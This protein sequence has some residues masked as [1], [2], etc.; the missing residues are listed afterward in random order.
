MPSKVLRK[1]DGTP[2]PFT[3]PGQEIQ[4]QSQQAN[5]YGPF[6]VGNAQHC[7]RVVE[8]DSHKGQHVILCG[9]GPSLAEHAAEWI[10]KGDVVM[11]TNSAATWL[12]DNGYRCDFALAIDQNPEMVAEWAS[13]PDVEYLLASTVHPHLTEYLLSKGRTIRWF[14]N[15]VGI[16]QRPVAYAYCHTCEGTEAFDAPSCTKC[17]AT[18]LERQRTSYED[19]LYCSLYPGTVRAGSGLNAVTR[20]IDVA[21]FMGFG[22]ITVLG[23]DHALRVKRPCP[24][25]VMFG[26]PEY[27]AWVRDETI[28]HADGG[29]GLASNATPVTVQAEIDSGT[30][31]RTVRPGHG[32]WWVTKPDMMLSAVWLMQMA[33][34]HPEIELIGET[35]SNALKGKDESFINALPG[36]DDGSG[37]NAA[38]SPAMEA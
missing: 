37:K 27:L 1:K 36:F 30:P 7:D 32:R 8:Q 23:A 3:K 9:A 22:R 26:T 15:F 21:R 11:A 13:A 31:D 4:L 16:K 18:E 24:A 2:A 17:G 14:H 25:D 35:L 12:I 33:K 10:P 34:H 29:S 5:N 6:I 38:Y 28:M 20:A 19:W